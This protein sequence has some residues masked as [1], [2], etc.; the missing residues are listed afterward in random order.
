M[1]NGHPLPNT[2]MTRFNGCLIEVSHS[3]KGLHIIGTYTGDEPDHGCKNIPLGLE[4]Y[5]SGRFVALGNMSTAVGDSSLNMTAQITATIPEYFPISAGDKP[6]TIDW[7]TTHDVTSNPITDDDALIA[8]ALSTQSA[9]S[10]FGGGG[11]ATFKDLWECNEEAL[12]DAFP[13]DMRGWDRSSADAALSQHLSFWC[14]GNC[15]R[16]DKLMRKSAL[17]RDKW[18]YHKS[19]IKRTVGGAVGRS[20]HNIIVLV[21]RLKLPNI[22]N[23]QHYVKV[24]N[25]WVPIK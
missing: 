23:V 18:D 17:V 1:V 3:N 25:S 8:K 24:I 11:K 7:T 19:Y 4:F 22:P 14:G 10:V 21:H 13:D 2:L 16:I 12:C 6:S 20:S 15:E 9:S 5:T